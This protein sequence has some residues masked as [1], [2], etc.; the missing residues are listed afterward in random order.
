MSR[1]M[2][3]ASEDQR[4]NRVRDST[5]PALAGDPYIYLHPRPRWDR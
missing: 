3:W 4:W 5:F 2:P 1:S